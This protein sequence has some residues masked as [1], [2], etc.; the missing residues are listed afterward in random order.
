MF[1]R[2]KV[3]LSLLEVFG[4][5]LPNTD[6]EKLLFLYCKRTKSTHYDFFPYKYGGFSFISYY[7]KRKL[8]EKGYL[9][10]V[11]KFQISQQT[12]SCLSQL[13]PSDRRAIKIFAAT[14]RNLRGKELVRTA[15]REYP[16]YTRK[17]EIA[18]QIL[19][20]EEYERVT[21]VWQI[22]I[23]P[24]LMT[25]GYEGMS[26]D[27]YLN[28]LIEN[29]VTALVDVRKNPI[30]RKFGFSKRILNNYVNKAGLEYYHLPDLGIASHLRKDLNGPASYQTLFELY[31]KQ[32][33]PEQKSALKMLKTITQVQKRIALTCFEADHTMC[34]RQKLV[35][36]LQQDLVSFYPINHL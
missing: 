3:L 16:E 5:T 26:I 4:G 6:F 18:S 23:E 15:Y 10:A 20:N 2:Q 34:H 14:T 11:D 27:A 7:D 31:E 1:Y 33:L 17:S 24:V 8:T 19:D 28:K 29:N 36:V 21:E 13:K 25:I 32:I 30:S 35:E 22:G 9:V 12:K